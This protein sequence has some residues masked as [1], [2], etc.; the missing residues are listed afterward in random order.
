MARRGQRNDRAAVRRRGC[1][2]IAAARV[3]RRGH[4]GGGVARAARAEPRGLRGAGVA[5]AGLR[6]AGKDRRCARGDGR[7]ARARAGRPAHAAGRLRVPPAPRRTRHLHS[8]YSGRAAS[9]PA[10]RRSRGAVARVRG[11]AR[12]RPP[13]RFVCRCCACESGM[14][15]GVLPLRMPEI[16]RCGCVAAG[17]RGAHGVRCRH[18]RRAPLPD[19]CLQRDNRWA[20]AYQAWLN[21]LPPAQRQRIGY[22]YNGRFEWPLSDVGFDW[23]TPAQEGV[24]VRVLAGEGNSG[25]AALRVQFRK[26]LCKG[27]RCSSS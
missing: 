20:D 1:D 6:A 4:A 12:W 14:V 5:G 3:P 25:R 16:R 27:P 22:I 17:I 8:R 11:R 13:R 10:P 2:R 19:G 9:P 21:S 26:K 18:R 7:G 24:D 23:T 15:A